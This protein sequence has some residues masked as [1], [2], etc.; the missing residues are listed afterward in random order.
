LGLAF[1]CVAGSERAVFLAEEAGA[2]KR[3]VGRA[4]IGCVSVAVTLYLLTSFAYVSGLSLTLSGI[5]VFG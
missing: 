3:T 1:S 5:L 2:D 4:V